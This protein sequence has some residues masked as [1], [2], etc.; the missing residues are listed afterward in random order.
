MGNQFQGMWMQ[1]A[2]G[3]AQ[4]GLA[5][6]LQRLGLGYD[7]RKQFKQTQ[8]LQELQLANES[9]LMDIQNQKQYEMWLKTNY[10]AQKEQMKLAGLNPGLMYGMGGGGGSTVGGGMPSPPGAM[11]QD[12]N[13]RAATGMGLMQ[14]AQIALIQAQKENIEADTKNKL[15]EV[16]VKDATVPNIK[17]DTLNK[18]KQFSEIEA[19]IQNIAQDTMKKVNEVEQLRIANKINDKSADDQIK[20]MKYD[21]IGSMLQNFLTKAQIG[22]TS[23]ETKNIKED[24]KLKTEQIDMVKRQVVNMVSENMREWDKMPMNE[25]MLRVQ[26]KLQEWNTDVDKFTVEQIT[27]LLSMGTIG[28]L[29]EKTPGH[30]PVKGFGQR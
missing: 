28:G 29:L 18:E 5:L 27:K 30:N 8:K 14:G 20:Q 13:T 1:A 12:P 10:G 23:A 7:Y 26:E 9:R 4:G 17:Q 2:A 16:P 22:K 19:R 6:G 25:R 11:A 21:A 24:T 15:A 3:A